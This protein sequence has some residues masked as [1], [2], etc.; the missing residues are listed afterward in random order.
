MPNTSR[1]GDIHSHGGTI[2][3]GAS[4]VVDQNSPTARI[5]DLAVCPIHG[6]V[7]IVTGNNTVI[8]EGSPTASI[9]DLLSCGAVIVTGASNV[10]DG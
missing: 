8:D 4:S 9:G 6:I 2:I 5:G 7:T 1:I 10:V 3:T